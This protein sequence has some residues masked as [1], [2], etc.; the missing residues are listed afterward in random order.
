MK[1]KI[2]YSKV[3]QLAESDLEE[4]FMRGDGPGNKRIN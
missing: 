2:D 3:P 4:N 1:K